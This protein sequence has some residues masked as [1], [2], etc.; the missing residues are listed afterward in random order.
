MNTR[1]QMLRAIVACMFVSAVSLSVE[2]DGPKDILIVANMAVPVNSISEA[3]LMAIF[4]KQRTSWKN[5]DKVIPIHTKNPKLKAQFLKRI[6]GNTITEDDTYWQAQKIKHGTSPPHEF[7]NNLKAVFRLKG[8][9]SY[10]YRSD[11]KKNV[12][13]ILLT[14]PQQ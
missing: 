10:I 5:G 7:G 8:A 3:E 12:V 2:A 4:L 13:K 6:L 1:F 11:Y 9:I 14:L